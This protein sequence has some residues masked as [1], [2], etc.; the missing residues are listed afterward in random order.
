M[1]QPE[2]AAA[3]RLVHLGGDEEESDRRSAKLT[4]RDGLV[5]VVVQ[6]EGEEDKATAAARALEDFDGGG[7]D[8][9]N[10]DG[11]DAGKTIGTKKRRFRSLAHIYKVTQ[12]VELH[13]EPK[14]R[15][16]WQAGS[17]VG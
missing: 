11:N 10:D 16:Q 3:K 5:P 1:T 7:D 8:D 14:R 6:G 15:K 12:P 9:G 2:V 4:E 17:L 13:S